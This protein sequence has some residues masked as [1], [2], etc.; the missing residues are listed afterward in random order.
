ML[1]LLAFRGVG[2]NE[3]CNIWRRFETDSMVQFNQPYLAIEIEAEQLTYH[4][5][6]LLREKRSDQFPVGGA[7]GAEVLG[8]QIVLLFTGDLKLDGHYIRS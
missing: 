7:R 8:A 6:V 4:H 1:K 3:A 2:C 5:V